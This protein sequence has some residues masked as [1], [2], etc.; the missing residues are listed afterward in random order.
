[1]DPVPHGIIRLLGVPPIRATRRWYYERRQFHRWPDTFCGV[2]GSFA[3]AARA[4]PA[5]SKVGYDHPEMAELYDESLDRVRPGDYPALFW[6]QRAF[7]EGVRTVFD[8]GGHIGISYYA[9]QRWVRF[10]DELAWR[11]CDLPRVLEAGRA[12]AGEQEANG[13]S[14][15][16]EFAEAAGV[17]LFCGLGSLQYVEQSLPQRLGSLPAL[18]KRLLLNRWPL[19]D[20]RPFVTLQHRGTYHPYAVFNRLEMVS[21]FEA[22]GYK[23]VDIWEVP[24]LSCT[25]PFHPDCAVPRYSGLY[26]CRRES[27]PQGLPSRTDSTS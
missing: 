17:D 7:D 5:G 27:M 19:T 2:Y 25:V 14:F 22:L 10:P 20:G 12:L 3:E 24:A 4:A 26:L 6:L 16:T 1:M 8:F 13:L 18:P 11:V 23:V 15:T 21:G 9:F